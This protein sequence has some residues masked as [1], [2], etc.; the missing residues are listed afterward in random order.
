[1]D[2]VLRLSIIQRNMNITLV[3]SRPY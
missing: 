3:N 1:M 2:F